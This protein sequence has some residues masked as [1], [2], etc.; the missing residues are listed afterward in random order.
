MSK[1][2]FLDSKF[3]DS[4]ALIKSELFF[5]V[6]KPESKKNNNILKSLD[7]FLNHFTA[8][9]LS[10]FDNYNNNSVT[11]ETFC[12]N[13][14]T[15]LCRFFRTLIKRSKLLSKTLTFGLCRLLSTLLAARTSSFRGFCATSTLMIA[16]TR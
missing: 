10:S 16:C 8:C 1:T 12:I 14:D 7:Q 5:E 4:K 15:Q 6:K 2:R 3:L 13:V 11:N 9:S